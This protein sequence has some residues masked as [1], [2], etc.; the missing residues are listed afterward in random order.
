MQRE[1][2][3]L[4]SNI[5]ATRGSDAFVQHSKFKRQLNVRV[6]ELE[7]LQSKRTAESRLWWSIRQGMPYLWPRLL[8]IMFYMGTPLFSRELNKPLIC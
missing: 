6:A 7:E 4:K 8:D 1:I 2:A 5:Q 3:E